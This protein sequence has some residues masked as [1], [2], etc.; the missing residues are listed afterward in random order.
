MASF[1]SWNN[2]TFVWNTNVPDNGSYENFIGKIASQPSK[3]ET[4]ADVNQSISDILEYFDNDSTRFT[5]FFSRFLDKNYSLYYKKTEEEKAKEAE[6]AAAAAGPKVTVTTDGKSKEVSTPSDLAKAQKMRRRAS[7]AAVSKHLQS[8]GGRRLSNL[9]KGL[10]VVDKAIELANQ[11]EQEDTK[12]GLKDD[13]VEEVVKDKNWKY[14]PYEPVVGDAVDE[15]LAE[16]LNIFEIDIDIRPLQLKKKK[17]K[18]GKGVKDSKKI[19]YRIQG[20]KRRIRCIHG[21]L[22]VK[23]KDQWVELIPKLRKLAGLPDMGAEQ[24]I[25]KIKKKKKGGR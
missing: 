18:R 2:R 7:K 24:A 14:L 21:V 4:V 13:E 20:K 11:E 23:E 19:F 22:L 8:D 3:L 25:D 17:K 12:L 10:Y 9:E 6:K 15:L 5:V 1:P 16:Q